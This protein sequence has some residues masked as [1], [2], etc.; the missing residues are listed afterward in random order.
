MMCA[1]NGKD[2][3]I[4]FWIFLLVG[5]ATCAFGVYGMFGPADAVGGNDMFMGF[6][7]GFGGTITL[8]AVI[9]LIVNALTPTDKQRAQ[10]IE[11][12]DERNVTIR[13]TACVA[14]YLA[15][16]ICDIIMAFL[17]IGLGYEVPALIVIGSMYVTVIT[18][19]IAKAVLNK[20]V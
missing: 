18:L 6:C 10:E 13:R 12:N 15:A 20:R 16:V 4:M 11:E 19:L 7:T 8:C 14:A 9:G 1:F 17:F 3:K 5:A 2:K